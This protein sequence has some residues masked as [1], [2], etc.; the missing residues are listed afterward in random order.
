MADLNLTKRDLEKHVFKGMA[1]EERHVLACSACEAPL[2]EIV[3][4]RKSEA[5]MGYAAR[6][7]HCGD[8]SFEKKIKGLIVM[9]HTDYTLR[10]SVEPEINSEGD[11]VAMIHTKVIIP[12]AQN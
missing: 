5:E 8:R 7:P 6:C 9:G 12:Y 10:V 4:V 3:V 2:A 1:I 11:E